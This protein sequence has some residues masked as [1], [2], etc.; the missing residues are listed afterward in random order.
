MLSDAQIERYSRQIIL[1][2][3]GGKGQEKLLRARVLVNGSGPLQT[4]ALYYL[5]AAGIGTVGVLANAPFPVF[6]ALVPGQEETSAAV[7]TALNPD[8]SVVVHRA[9]DVVTPERFVQEYD[10][11]LSGPDPLHEAC[12]AARRPFVCAHVSGADAWLFSCRGYEPD[13]PCLRC[14]PPHFSQGSQEAHPFLEMASLFLGT[15]QATEVIKII[16]GLQQNSGATLFRCQFPALHLFESR[17][18][19]D[20][21]CP[22]CR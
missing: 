10:I 13:L 17:V 20:P 15:L 22:L 18:S 2:Q 14:L 6:C 4:A 19:K 7:L 1:P 11:V 16:L 21:A 12:Y 9:G 3:V 8:C 5:A